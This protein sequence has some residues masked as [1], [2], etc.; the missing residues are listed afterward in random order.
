MQQSNTIFAF[1]FFAFLFFIT[2]R[3]ELR[4]YLGFLFGTPTQ[5]GNSTVASLLNAASTINNAVALAPGVAVP[6]ATG[7]TSVGGPTG[8]SPLV[9]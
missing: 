1:L 9:G 5:S 8:P 6:G 7:P 2:A 4:D 3:G